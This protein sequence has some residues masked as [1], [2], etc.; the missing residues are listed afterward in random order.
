M[1]PADAELYST[2]LHIYMNTCGCCLVTQRLSAAAVT[3]LPGMY[4]V[5]A[6]SPLTLAQQHASSPQA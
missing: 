2:T 4:L 3:Q 6:C 5:S 1:L